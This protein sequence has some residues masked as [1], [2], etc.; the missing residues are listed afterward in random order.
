[1]GL[2]LTVDN[3]SGHFLAQLGRQH[4]HVSG[5]DNE[6]NVVL[7]DEL[8][9]L[10]LLLQL[11][12]LGHRYVVELNAVALGQGLKVGVV[13]DND[14]HLNEQLASLHAEQQVVEAVANLGHHDEHAGA[15]LQGPEVVGHAVLGGE[16]LEVGLEVL[17]RRGI[18]NVRGR[19][20][21]HAHEELVGDGVGEL[22]QVEHVV[23]LC[24]ED[25]RDGVDNAGLVGAAEGEDVAGGS[26]CD[27]I[28]R[29]EA[30]DLLDGRSAISQRRD[31]SS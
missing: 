30:Q 7:L 4:L 22:L 31:I 25:S 11:G 10:G 27:G 29:V 24:G 28:S 13:G 18:G 21:V 6:L 15:A 2:R 23:A 12:V 3:L 17:S 9:H 20:K 8:Q 5:Q 26:H 14:G 19:A 1:M 16:G